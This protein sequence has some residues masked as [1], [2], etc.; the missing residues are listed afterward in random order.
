MPSCRRPVLLSCSAAF[1][2]TCIYEY[3]WREGAEPSCRRPFLLSCS[4]SINAEV[5]CI[6]ARRSVRV[7]GSRS[8]LTLDAENESG[9]ARIQPWLTCINAELCSYEQVSLSLSLSLIHTHTHTQAL[10]TMR[11]GSRHDVCFLIGATMSH[12][13]RAPAA[14]SQE[15]HVA[16]WCRCEHARAHTCVCCLLLC[17]SVFVYVKKYVYTYICIRTCG[18]YNAV[19]CAEFEKLM[20]C[21]C[22]AACARD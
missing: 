11:N 17:V 15:F 19:P 16:G 20:C 2:R 1:R 7:L 14:N 4:V 9:G 21:V 12:R 5:C 10:L 13:T 6:A 8:N 18:R 3:L 22:A